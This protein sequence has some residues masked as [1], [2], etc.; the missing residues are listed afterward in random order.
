[1]Q[2]SSVVQVIQKR[3]LDPLE[4]EVQVNVSPVT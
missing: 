1:M 3:V 2:V 4:P